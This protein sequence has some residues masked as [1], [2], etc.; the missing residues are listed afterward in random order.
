M[1]EMCLDFFYYF[2]R[3]FCSFCILQVVQEQALNIR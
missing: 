1:L 2:Q 3:V